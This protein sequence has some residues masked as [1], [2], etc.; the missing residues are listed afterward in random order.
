MSIFCCNDYC[1]TYAEWFISYRPPRRVIEEYGYEV[2]FISQMM[3]SMHGSG[4]GHTVYFYKRAL[5]LVRA[6][7][8]ERLV[9]MPKRAGFDEEDEEISCDAAFADAV[10]LATG[11]VA[12]LRQHADACVAEHLASERPR[13]ERRPR[14]ME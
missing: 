9:T 5:P 8:R 2:E 3:T 11:S 1:S 7:A 6:P 14:V 12:D 10:K 4:E 13:R